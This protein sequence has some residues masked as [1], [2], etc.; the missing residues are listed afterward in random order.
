MKTI[1][2]DRNGKIDCDWGL[3]LCGRQTGLKEKA[4]ENNILVFLI[5][6]LFVN[7]S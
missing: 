1:R 7:K 2:K 5:E 3:I 6:R 4:D